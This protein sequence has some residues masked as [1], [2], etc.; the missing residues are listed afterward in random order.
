MAFMRLIIRVR[1]LNLRQITNLHPNREDEFK[2]TGEFLL[3][4]KGNQ[5]KISNIKGKSW[6]HK[7]NKNKWLHI[8]MNQINVYTNLIYVKCLNFSNARSRKK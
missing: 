3:Y 1:P 2:S 6:T 7:K 4:E 8:T 5:Y